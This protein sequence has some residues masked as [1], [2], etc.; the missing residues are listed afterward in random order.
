M[1]TVD[2]LAL[3]PAEFGKLGVDGGRMSAVHD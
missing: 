2:E 3:N 1:S